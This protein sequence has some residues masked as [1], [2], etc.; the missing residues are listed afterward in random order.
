MK[1]VIK[2]ISVIDRLKSLFSNARE[3]ELMRWHS[4]N[5]KQSNKQI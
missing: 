2:T 4:E 3:A 5:R 1:T